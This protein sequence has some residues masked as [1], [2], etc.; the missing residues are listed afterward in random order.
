MIYKSYLK[1]LQPFLI[2]EP[3]SIRY[4]YNIYFELHRLYA[5][6]TRQEHKSQYGSIEKNGWEK[7][8]AA[9]ACQFK[10]VIDTIKIQSLNYLDR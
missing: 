8:K 2:E 4:E 9:Y 6:E 1:L 10:L 5:K 7:Q 3:P